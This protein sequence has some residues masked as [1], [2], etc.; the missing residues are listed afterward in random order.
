MQK[1]VVVT[2]LGFVTPVGSSVESF[3]TAVTKGSS[4]IRLIKSFDTSKLRT[5]YAGIVEDFPI[6]DLLTDKEL[7]RLDRT[8]QF[9]IL[10]AKLALDDADLLKNSSMSGSRV[11]EPDS[12]GICM[13]TGAGSVG[14][15]EK[16]Y[17]SFFE[18]GQSDVFAIPSSMHH[19]PTGNVSIK[20][21]L[22]GFN[23]T[24]S[25]ACSSGAAAIGV[26]FN[27]I[28]YGNIKRM[29]AGGVEASITKCHLE[30]WTAMRVLSPEKEEP[31]RAM[32]PFS[33]NRSGFL[34]G[35]G[36][37]LVVLEELESALARGCKIYGEIV[38]FGSTS[39]GTHIVNPSFEG[40]ALAIE[41]ALKSAKIA[42]EQIGYI[43]AHGTATSLNDKVE[44]QA[45]KKIFGKCQIPISSIKPITGHMLAASGAAE[46]ATAILAAKEGLIPPT[47]NYE[48]LDPDCDLDYVTEGARKAEIEYTMS[49]SFGFGGSNAV[50]VSKRWN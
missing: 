27:E 49:T 35:E 40:Q 10:A 18:N 50:L 31:A 25:T 5:K 26:A 36:A 42:P 6:K 33:K 45:I 24:I 34:L 28:R 23:L 7:S 46:F 43:N 29:V 3:L 48:Q 16:S 14:A 47:I 30:N 4:G 12:I 41:R 9:S 38:G 11:E 39:D 1:Q 44:T 2:G 19:S 15:L 20:Y 21:G 37:A 13:G 8:A 17:K 22:H 32:K